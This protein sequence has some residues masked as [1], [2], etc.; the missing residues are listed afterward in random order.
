MMNTLLHNTRLLVALAF[1]AGAAL[2]TGTFAAYQ[3]WRPEVTRNVVLTTDA[4]W[5]DR[6]A[7]NLLEGNGFSICDAPPYAPHLVVPPLC[8]SALAGLYALFGERP[9][10]G[11]AWN[12][13]LSIA[14]MVLFPLAVLH[15]TR[16]RRAVVAAAWLMALSPTFVAHGN[17][18]LME[19]AYGMFLIISYLVASWFLREQSPGA[20]V[21][22]GAT[23]GILNL[24]KFSAL[25]IVPMF[26]LPY[27]I[28]GR[29]TA[30]RRRCMLSAIILGVF[31]IAVLPWQLR[32]YSVS[33][34]FAYTSN[35]WINPLFMHMREYQQHVQ[36]TNSDA[37]TASYIAR[38][39]ERTGT[40]FY[41]D[42][43]S[44]PIWQMDRH[45]TLN[46]YLAMRAVFK[47]ELAA[48]RM[49]YFLF[50]FSRLPQFFLSVPAHEWGRQ[51]G[52]PEQD[53]DAVNRRI[54]AGDVA[55]LRAML[56]RQPAVTWFVIGVTAAG[57][58]YLVIVYM[59]AA[60]G[61]W[62]GMAKG[63]EVLRVM[64]GFWLVWI[65]FIIVAVGPLA[66]SRYRMPADPAFMAL[67]AVGFAVL[68]NRFRRAEGIPAA[69]G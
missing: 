15:L 44:H 55:G 14:C 62:H 64:T 54:A 51:L 12:V 63:G 68:V 18:L 49:G 56:G 3:P 45:Y 36:G 20:A 58:A 11:V 42:T 22:L 17:S 39:R 9:F 28:L 59:L 37:V 16:D 66:H 2:R 61:A 23:F 26:A 38:I 69:Q 31:Y 8:P 25:F 30:L 48:D 24:V 53:L 33:G 21:M 67:A 46:D 4:V 10:V 27:L 41:P 47:E 19:Q 1:V 65:A 57:M 29:T 60:F 6:L 43:N 34:C 40:P 52:F 5:Q 13:L 35:K 32:N 7:R 50:H